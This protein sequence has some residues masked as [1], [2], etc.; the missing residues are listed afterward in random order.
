MVI[1]LWLLASF[2]QALGS[3]IDINRAEPLVLQLQ[4]RSQIL[5][6]DLLAYDL[7]GELYLPIQQLSELLKLQT[8]VD[9]D[10][11]QVEGQLGYDDHWFRLQS[12][13]L[14]RVGQPYIKL[15]GMLNDDWDLFIPAPQMATWWQLDVDYNALNQQLA[16]TSRIELPIDLLWARQQRQQQLEKRQQRQREPKPEISANA[17]IGDPSFYGQLSL[18]QDGSD[19]DLSLQLDAISDIAHH[20]SDLYLVLD[21]DTHRLRLGLQKQLDTPLMNFYRFGSIT[22]QASPLLFGGQ[23][24]WGASLSQGDSLGADD[25]STILLEG[26][27]PIGWD[28]ELYRNGALLD[29]QRINSEGRY[30]FEQVPLYL[31]SNRFVIELYGPNGERQQL[32]FDRPVDTSILK[33]GEQQWQLSALKRED[34]QGIESQFNWG[35]GLSEQW[36][37]QLG[38]AQQNLDHRGG[39]GYVSAVLSGQL[40]NT[41]SQFRFIEQLA[42]GYALEFSS[43]G[44]LGDWNW[45]F[46]ADYLSDF[47][48]SVELHEANQWRWNTRLFGYW[49]QLGWQFEAEGE[50]GNYTNTTVQTQG[51]SKLGNWVHRL[52]WQD[53]QHSKITQQFTLSGRANKVRIR[54]SADLSWQPEFELAR[55]GVNL[56]YPLSQRNSAATELSYLPTTKGKWFLSQ[57]LN[58]QFPKWLFSVSLSGNDEDYLARMELSTGSLWQTRNNQWHWS[59]QDL[60][61]QGA[62]E[63]TA[64]WDQNGDGHQNEDEPGLAGIGFRCSGC[65]P[66]SETDNNGKLLLTDLPADSTIRLALIEASLPDPFMKASF[67]TKHLQLHS[68]LVERISLAVVMTSEIEGRVMMTTAAREEVAA[69]GMEVRLFRTENGV[70]QSR[71]VIDF[72]GVFVLDGIPPGAY[73]LELRNHRYPVTLSA[74]GEIVS[75]GTIYLPQQ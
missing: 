63:I 44:Y 5:S 26:P 3:S 8:L 9:L 53:H 47:D 56:N 55:V 29:A 31:G 17:A 45:Q 35:M 60:T 41:L 39:G 32:S 46:N 36:S 73:E 10:H 70:L 14:S 37:L 38:L 27:A 52:L 28:A 7:D 40:F 12:G 66:Q 74:D 42:Q 64:Y 54:G 19:T 33:Q 25:I 43:Q 51:R 75:L 16:L 65:K 4:Y 18:N 22:N 61:T 58:Y 48:S 72:D 34:N 30:R 62:M 23:L 49:Q 69:K 57:Y 1:S 20:Q 21:E 2:S 24:G 59:A 11:N 15:D 13:L 71:G 50:S 6:D 67:V 68:G